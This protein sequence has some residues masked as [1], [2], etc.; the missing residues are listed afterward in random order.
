M[1]EFYR[2]ARREDDPLDRPKVGAPKTGQKWAPAIEP[3]RRNAKSKKDCSFCDTSWRTPR[4]IDLC[5]RCG[6]NETQQ[7]RGPFPETSKNTGEQACAIPTLGAPAAAIHMAERP[8]RTRAAREKSQCSVLK[9]MKMHPRDLPPFKMSGNRGGSPSWF[10][11]IY[12]QC[13]SKLVVG[14]PPFKMSGNR[15]RG[16]KIHPPGAKIAIRKLDPRNLKFPY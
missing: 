14:A 15:H 2:A 13:G 11:Y 1:K 3:K 7:G 10:I 6:Q 12:R 4:S 5:F 9:F 16:L 8:R